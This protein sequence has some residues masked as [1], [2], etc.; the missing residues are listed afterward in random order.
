MEEQVIKDR[1]VG[2]DISN[3]LTTYAIV[4]V[5][6]NIYAEESFDTSLYPDVNDLWQYLL[7]RSLSW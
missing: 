4:D 7:R 5:R 3:T 1:V 2:I 6:G